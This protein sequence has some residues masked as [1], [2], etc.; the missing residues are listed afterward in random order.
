MSKNGNEKF[1]NEAESENI[2]GDDEDFD[3]HLHRIV[4]HPTT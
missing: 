1:Q 3:P 4:P 2:T